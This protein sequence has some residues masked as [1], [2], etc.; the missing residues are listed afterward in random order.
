[1]EAMKQAAAELSTLGCS[2]VLVKG[3]HV[4]DCEMIE[5]VDDRRHRE[6]AK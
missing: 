6:S 3:G 1:M 4:I 5:Y 2:C